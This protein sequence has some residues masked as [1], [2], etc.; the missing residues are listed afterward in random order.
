MNTLTPP[1]GA[2][3]TE[4]ANGSPSAPLVF[5]QESDVFISEDIIAVMR[6]MGDCRIIH[7]RDVDDIAPALARAPQIAVAL[8]EAG[9][10]DLMG[11]EAA[12]LLAKQGAKVILTA[13]SRDE[14]QISS[15]GWGMLRRPFS[16]PMLREELARLGVAIGAA[17]KSPQL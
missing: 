8:I 9:F 10:A 13:V 5:I 16:D 2:Q 17:S 12:Q 1:N 15:A 11:G 3:V 4:S 14:Q 6:A 7:V